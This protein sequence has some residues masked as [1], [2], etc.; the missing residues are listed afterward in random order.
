MVANL[1]DPNAYNK[2][3]AKKS[4]LEQFGSA[5]SSGE[6]V[7][8]E[9]TNDNNRSAEEVQ[10]QENW[11]SERPASSAS[12]QH[13]EED[14]PPQAKGEGRDLP[15]P[16]GGAVEAGQGRHDN[17]HT[18]TIFSEVMSAVFEQTPTGFGLESKVQ[19]ASIGDNILMDLIAS[20]YSYQ[21][22]FITRWGNM[23]LKGTF[24]TR[25]MSPCTSRARSPCRGW[26]AA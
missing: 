21:S 14:Q 17:I 20:C 7:F 25:A 3:N 13:L 26:T 8:E 18:V 19:A 23:V 1:L 4:P 9:K 16:E 12:G 22:K 11:Y 6:E 5:G 10:I 24:L 15:L 2:P